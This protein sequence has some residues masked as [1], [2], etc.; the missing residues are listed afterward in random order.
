MRLP[1][2]R[3][4]SG[5]YAS[6]AA[7]T[8]RN[9][10]ASSDYPVG[11][12]SP[13]FS[14]ASDRRAT[15]NVSLPLSSARSSRQ[16]VSSTISRRCRE[17]TAPPP[18]ATFDPSDYP[19]SPP[20]QLAHS[21]CLRACNLHISNWGLCNLPL[22]KSVR[23]FRPVGAPFPLFSPTKTT[24]KCN[25]SKIRFPVHPHDYETGSPPET[26]WTSWMKSPPRQIAQQNWQRMWSLLLRFSRI[27]KASFPHLVQ[28]IL[29]DV[30]SANSC[31]KAFT[32]G[33]N[34]PSTECVGSHSL[35]PTGQLILRMAVKCCNIG[36]KATKCTEIRT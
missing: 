17:S 7:P 19:L 26:V 9:Q 12:L 18:S 10:S 33:R 4:V 25:L 1:K 13:R 29:S 15:P 24:R 20:L 5:L 32:P 21:R 14:C 6:T 30:L 8:S 35:R 31:V 23:C 36:P 34:M 16:I 27:V 11:D 28:R 2:L 3:I 22:T